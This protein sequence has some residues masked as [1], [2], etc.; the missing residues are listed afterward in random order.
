[1]TMACVAAMSGISLDCCPPIRSP[2]WRSQQEPSS[3]VTR[4]VSCKY[5]VAPQKQSVDEGNIEGGGF[6]PMSLG[7]AAVNALFSYEPFFKF[8]AGQAR[9]MIIKRGDKIGYPWG[10]E[11]AKLRTH[12]W[13][14]ELKKA[15]NKHVEYPAYYLKPFHAYEYG[16]LSW[17]AAWEVE[18]AAKSV[19]AN[20]F[21]PEKKRLDPNGDEELRNSYHKTMLPMLK[22]TPQAVV[23]LGCATGLSTYGLHEVFPNAH[24]VGVDLSPY[25][26]S[27]ANYR[28]R[29]RGQ[30]KSVQ[31]LH[32]AAEYTGLPSGAYDLV[33]LCLVCHELPRSAT[34]QIVE[35]AHRLLKPGG[36]LA[37]MEMNPY[38]PYLQSMVN[39]VFAFTAFKATE[40][41][42]DDYRTF[43][44]EKAIE[45]RGF[46][47]PSQR[48]CS[49]RHRTIVAYKK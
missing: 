21:D 36:A 9:S 28:Q 34:K 38:S 42:F 24:T 13:S 2:T 39:N 23:D 17:D 40:P 46:T 15:Q 45:E 20:T 32:A 29:E 8:A 14:E 30:S 1:M 22:T 37:I 11:L 16:N 25:F 3:C 48:E 31:F 44:I 19:H 6:T 4:N 43:G 10:P 41:Y 18:L 5:S 12:D 7:T 26:I 49:P 47:F 27:V 35:E 33:S